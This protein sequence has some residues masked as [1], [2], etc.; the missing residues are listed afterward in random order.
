M[1]RKRKPPAEAVDAALTE[2]AAAMHELYPHL[3]FIPLKPGEQPPPG[4]IVVRASGGGEPPAGLAEAVADRR[5]LR[6]GRVDDDRGD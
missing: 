3:E 1:G 2:L 5:R 6:R 4:T